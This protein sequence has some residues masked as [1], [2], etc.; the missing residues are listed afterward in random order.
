MLRRKKNIVVTGSKG[1]LGS[2]LVKYF[3]QL[4]FKKNSRIG[5]VFGIDKEDLDITN[6]EEV[7]N[8]FNMHVIDPPI[9]IDYVVHCAA[10][11][12]TTAIEK[13]PTAH[14]ATNALGTKNI[15][16]SCAY[17][18]I[19][20]ICIST[21]YVFSENSPVFGSRLQ[22]FPINQYGLQKLIG[23]LFAKEA[24]AKKKNDLSI[25][26]SSWMFGNSTSSFVEKFLT[27]AF[28]AYAHTDCD[29]K[30]EVKVV[31]DAYGKPTS[32]WLIAQKI[33]AIIEN[34]FHGEFNCNDSI[35]QISRYGW[36]NMIWEEFLDDH[37]QCS[38]DDSDLLSSLRDNISIVPVA[39]S[40]L[41]LPLKHPGQVDSFM[42]ES[43]DY[44]EYRK[45]TKKYIDRNW[46]RLL[47]LAKSIIE[48]KD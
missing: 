29:G 3:T 4:S 38:I 21:D 39:S 5:K 10:S 19:K 15:A 11:T 46:H 7:S 48:S 26:R 42:L 36:A 25:I 18:G 20:L 40:S 28:N 22:E 41:A 8:H 23:E 34:N 13:D 44:S 2:Y 35:G 27:T 24:Y 14:Y 9:D 6:A 16:R 1:Q 30:V 31:D 33:K 43:K 47:D 37:R 32:V 45:D 12:N 17:N